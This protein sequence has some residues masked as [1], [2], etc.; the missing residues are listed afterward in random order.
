MHFRKN[1]CLAKVTHNKVKALIIYNSY[2][3]WLIFLLHT[4]S[5]LHM[6]TPKPNRKICKRNSSQKE[7][8]KWLWTQKFP[9]SYVLR[10]PFPPVR[11]SNIK[12]SARK[13]WEKAPGLA[14]ERIDC[15]RALCNVYQNYNCRS[16][17]APRIPLVELILWKYLHKCKMTF[18]LYR[19]LW[20]VLVSGWDNHIMEY[21]AVIKL[22]DLGGQHRKE[23][24]S[25]LHQFL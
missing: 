14:A 22:V 8:H 25:L 11:Q 17:F 16:P 10:Y 1:R 3:K 13:K 24:T 5:T 19:A 4:Y 23:A 18:V 21:C 2:Y 7:I 12:N 20:F 15:P 9:F 6:K